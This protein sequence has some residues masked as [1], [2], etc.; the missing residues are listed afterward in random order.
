LFHQRSLGLFL[1]AALLS[2]CGGSGTP[3]FQGPPP[4]ARPNTVGT[5]A[6]YTGTLTE[7]D[8]NNLIAATPVTTTNSFAVTNAI[9]TGAD[10]QGNSTFTSTES[11][12]S[13]LR[14]L[15]TTT[16][17]TVAYQ[18]QASGTV[19]VRALKTV[20][21]DSNGVI[22][23]ADY[24][25]N[26]GLLTLLPENAGGFTNDA[27]ATY[28]ETDPGQNVSGGTQAVTTERDVNADGS[29][30]QTTGTFDSSLAPVTNTATEKADFSGTLQL[31]NIPKTRT[32]TFAAPAGAS[33]SY[34]YHNGASGTN[35]TT[36]VPNWIPPT[37][38]TPSVET[39]TIAPASAID[40]ACKPAP[41]FGTSATKVTQ[42][43]TT[44]DAVLG[45]L[46]KRV[47]ASYD[48]LGAGTICATVSDTLQTFYDF[49]EQ[50]GPAPRLFPSGS[51]TV[52][53]ETVTVTE[54]L[55]L[56]SSVA[57]SAARRAP[58]AL[59][60]AGLVLPPSLVSARVGRLVHERALRLAALRTSG[61]VSL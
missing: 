39:D 36:T 54:T 30:T 11:D 56:Q 58:S 32:F 34:V 37:V 51:A 59:D 25:S 16:V 15:T 33:I 31:N 29:Y 60:A 27:K 9:A 12:A 5:Q 24:G 61:G 2:G 10:A 35:T 13:Q 21:T 57:P 47:T 53:A 28:K 44:A 3:A 6:Q 1:G 26:N 52:P 7:S 45:T 8:V 20:A 40:P 42:T 43:V 22:T 17:A 14:T 4:I 55:A 18:Q 23:E 41:Q 50:E 46:E 38:T 19:S 49:S 48:V